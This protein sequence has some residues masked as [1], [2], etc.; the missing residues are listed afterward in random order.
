MRRPGAPAVV[1]VASTV[2]TAAAQRPP[3]APSATAAAP[4]TSSSAAASAAAPVDRRKEEARAHFDRGITL[5]EEGAWDPA[6]AEFTRS[7]QLYPTRAATKNAALCL[8]KLQRFDEA[9]DAFETLL[10]EFPNLPADDRETAERELRELSAL[11]GRIELRGGEPGSTVVVDTRSRGTLPLAHVRVGAGTHVVRV[12]KEG[13]VPF[14]GQVTVAGGQ[15][16]AVDV[17]LAPLM[18]GGR[19]RVNEQ[20]GKAVSVLVDNVV[21]GVT[22]WEGTL[23]VGDHTVVL[24]GEGNLGTQPASAPVKLNQMTALTLSVEE[25]GARLRIEPSPSIAN[26]AIDGVVVGRGVWEGKLRAGGHRV[27]LASS[28]YFSLTRDVSVDAGAR[29]VVPLAL[30]RDPSAALTFREAEEIRQEWLKRGGLTVTWELRAQ[31]TFLLLPHRPQRIGSVR[32]GQSPVNGPYV[33]DGTRDGDVFGG[34]GGGGLGAR[35]ALLH[36]RLDDPSTGRRWTSLRLGTGVDVDLLYANP[37]LP[38]VTTTSTS[39]ANHE[40]TTKYSAEV[41]GANWLV[42]VPL[43]L[44][45]QVGLGSYRAGE[46]KGLALGLAWAPSW[47]LSKASGFSSTH[48]MNYAAFE[49]SVDVLDRPMLSKGRSWYGKVFGYVQPPIGEDKPLRVSVGGGIAWY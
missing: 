5:F 7:R 47:T 32:V 37:A 35:F 27:E 15:T 42:T 3:P 48:T 4:S 45:A 40:T 16:T 18:Q 49:L 14:E 31:G 6:L 30:E 46:W 20:S 28:G 29:R 25:L 17:R 44:G 21:V 34:G 19:L 23:P 13:F 8:R 26:I 10:K 36:L 12:V 1:L 39:A 38:S 11:V 43:T 24:D 9:Q 2:A 33:I 22:P 41:W